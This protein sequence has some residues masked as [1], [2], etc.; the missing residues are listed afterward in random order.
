MEKVPMTEGSYQKL[1]E[2]I[3]LLKG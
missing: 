2:E 1:D 3:K